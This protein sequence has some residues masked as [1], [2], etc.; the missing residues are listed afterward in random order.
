MQ[1]IVAAISLHTFEVSA[2]AGIGAVL[3]MHAEDRMLPTY[4]WAWPMHKASA[5]GAG[6]C[7]ILEISARATWLLESKAWRTPPSELGLW[8]AS[9]NHKMDKLPRR[10][11]PMDRDCRFASGYT[12]ST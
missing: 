7:R 5:Y 10:H 12:L 3:G 8:R 9:C 6:D 2:G 1:D 11:W 4:H